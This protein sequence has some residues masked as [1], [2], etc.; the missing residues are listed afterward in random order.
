VLALRR[1]NEAFCQDFQRNVY[2][3]PEVMLKCSSF[4]KVVAPFLENMG[5]VSD[6]R[7]FFATVFID[8]AS[9]SRVARLRRG[10]GWR[11]AAA[12][13]LDEHSSFYSDNARFLLFHLALAEEKAERA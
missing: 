6:W 11:G 8:R 5:K 9:F 1:V 12:E 13:Q 7:V 2:N 10:G 3:L 4:A